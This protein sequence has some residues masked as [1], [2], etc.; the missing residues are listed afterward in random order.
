MLLGSLLQTELKVIRELQFPL[1]NVFLKKILQN[2]LQTV[3]NMLPD[4][5]IPSKKAC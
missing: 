5:S 1:R 4:N 2:S 3:L